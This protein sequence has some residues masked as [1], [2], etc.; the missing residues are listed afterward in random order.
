MSVIKK[1]KIMKVFIHHIYEYEKGVRNLI[2]HTMMKKYK[3]TV[4]KKLKKKNI[5][6]LIRELN[7]GTFNVFFGD[8]YCIKLLASFGDKKLNE[9]SNE[10]DF[11]LG[12]MLGYGLDQ[13]CQ[14]YLKRRKEKVEEMFG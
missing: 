11:I 1:G 10:E 9:F 8:D 4:E 14:R 2:L 3:N 7:N 6:Y 5:S 12:V 13:Q